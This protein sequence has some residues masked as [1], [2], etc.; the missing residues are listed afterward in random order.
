MGKTGSIGNWQIEK[1][2]NGG[3]FANALGTQE[4]IINRELLSHKHFKFGDQSR[5]LNIRTNYLCYMDFRDA[6]FDLLY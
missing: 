2:F 5:R 6:L 1:S 3:K 4:K